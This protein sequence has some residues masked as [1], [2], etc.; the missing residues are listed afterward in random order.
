[1]NTLRKLGISFSH[2]VHTAEIP[3]LMMWKCV[4]TCERQNEQARNTFCRYKIIP[5]NIP[6][7]VF[8]PR[9]PL[10]AVKQKRKW[11]KFYFGKH[12]KFC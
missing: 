3:F 7:K 12:D 5:F 1:M 2:N 8:H 11:V 4:Y 9:F 10:G 6:W